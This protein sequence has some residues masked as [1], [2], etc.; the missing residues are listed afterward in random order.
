[1]AKSV[2]AQVRPDWDGGPVS[3]WSEAILL[4]GSP[5]S[6]ALLLCT[7]LVLRFRTAWGG[8][9]VFVA[10]SFA[11]SAVTFFDPTGGLR[12]AATAEGCIGSPTLFIALVAAIGIG[13]LLYTGRPKDNEDAP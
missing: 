4:F 10:W 3:A 8:L 9:I 7:A 12:A 6:L 2:C 11:V 1:M 5:I 13:T